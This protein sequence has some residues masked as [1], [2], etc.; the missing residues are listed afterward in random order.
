MPLPIK[1][2]IVAIKYRLK[3]LANS[4]TQFHPTQPDICWHRSVA[5]GLNIIC[6]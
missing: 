5:N 6:W 1:I 3:I 4:T 2:Y